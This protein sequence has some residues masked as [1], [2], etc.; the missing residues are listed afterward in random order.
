[1]LMKALVKRGSVLVDNI[2]KG[3]KEVTMDWHE[4]I[5]EIVWLADVTLSLR[6]YME[7][8]WRVMIF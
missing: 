8:I 5:G 1:M 3:V 2:K 7:T 4:Y 6:E